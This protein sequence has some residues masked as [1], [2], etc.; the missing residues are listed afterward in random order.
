MLSE[1]ELEPNEYIIGVATLWN[2]HIYGDTERNNTILETSWFLYDAL[3]LDELYETE[4]DWL[5]YYTT[6]MIEYVA[7]FNTHLYS[8]LRNYSTII[9]NPQL[10]I[11]KIEY[12]NSH[13]IIV[14]KKTIWLKIIQRRW[15]K[16][17]KKR[18][19][20]KNIHTILRRQLLGK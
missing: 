13:H 19:Q 5:A 6:I 9:S 16:R 15:K 18:M 2:K 14:T 3:T 17:Y 11:L 1:D 8:V 12:L 10:D 4:F 20:M 7:L